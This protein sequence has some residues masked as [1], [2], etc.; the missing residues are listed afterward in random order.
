MT[1]FDQDLEQKREVLAA[2]KV[3]LESQGIQASVTKYV[4]SRLKATYS[5]GLRCRLQYRAI[6]DS[7]LIN[8]LICK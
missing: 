8:I 3:F 7:K 5:E 4:T 1:S 2:F 6:K